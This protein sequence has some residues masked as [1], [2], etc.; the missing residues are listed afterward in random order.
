MKL[1]EKLKIKDKY[2]SFLTK[3]ISFD[4]L[5]SDLNAMGFEIFNLDNHTITYK[6]PDEEAQ[7]PAIK[8]QDNATRIFRI[9][10]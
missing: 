2:Y 10:I 5:E 8:V 6:Y 4:R 3:K 7:L 1:K 9:T